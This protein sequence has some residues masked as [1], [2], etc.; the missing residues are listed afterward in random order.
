MHK[1]C[2][3]F[4]ECAKDNAIC[5]SATALCEC[6]VNHKEAKREEEIFCLA[7][8]CYFIYLS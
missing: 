2:K 7:S 6:D 5:N 4:D 8:T 1:D 3:G